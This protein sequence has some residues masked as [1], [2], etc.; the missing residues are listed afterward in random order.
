MEKHEPIPLWFVLLV[1]FYLI[2]PLSHSQLLPINTN[3]HSQ[4]GD[5]GQTHNY[6]VRVKKPKS[7]TA[8][9]LRRWHESFLP[10]TTLD[11]GDPRLIYSYRDV[12]S[13]FAARLTPEELIAM[14]AK[15]G[16]LDVQPE[17]VHQLQTTYTP[18]FLGLSQRNG[19]TWWN[20]GLGQGIIIGVIDTGITP[21]HPSFKDDGMPPSP[22]RWKGR[23][24]RT[25][26][27]TCNNK[28]IG[29]AA[30]N[31]TTVST[32]IDT[33]GHGTHVAGTAAGNFVNG[34]NVL[35]TAT[36]TAAGMAPRAHLAIYKVCHEHGCPGADILAAIDQ[37]IADGVDVLSISIGSNTTYKFYWDPVAQGS[38][39]ALSYGIMT[40]TSAGNQ[41]PNFETLSHD[42][43]WVMAV[44][45]SATDRRISAIVKLG[46]GTELPGES[47]FQPSA[48]DSSTMLPL[49]FPG[50]FG[51]YNATFCVDGSLDYIDVRGKIV[52]CSTGLTRNIEKGKVVYSAGG[53]AMIL[54]NL[55]QQGYTTSPDAHV[56]PV[57]NLG[58]RDGYEVQTYYYSLM[59]STTSTATAT[60]IFGGT[61]FGNRPSPAVGAFSSRGPATKNGGIIKPDVLAPGVNILAAWPYD[62]GP[63]PSALA[64]STFNFL[65]G[66]SM[67]APHVSGVVALIMNRHPSWPPA[68]IQS[69]IITSADDLNLDGGPIADQHTNKN[70]S[71]FATGSGQVNPTAA[72]D[73][74]L[75][76][77][78]KPN[79]YIGYVCGLGYTDDELELLYGRP[80]NCLTTNTIHAWMLNYPS[81]Q[82]S[83]PRSGGVVRI[84]RTATNVGDP[85]SFYRAR[86]TEPEGVRVDLSTY[87]LQFSWLL[88]EKSFDV[89]LRISPIGPG[90]R[91]YSD[92]KIEWVSYN[93]VVKNTIAV[94]FI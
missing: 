17:Q 53:A 16:V 33:D 48:F 90:L 37:A 34:A 62:V 30:F 79:D 26:G 81:I 91:K 39:S 67:A 7:L 54:V 77:D 61:T 40:V 13:G 2:L 44:G 72:L 94:T 23:C 59:N 18:E 5:I 70:A 42:A 52:I 10:N 86:I 4:G 69:A 50:E 3:D 9:D 35:G 56:L 38:L 19:G 68:I 66:T 93:R 14:Q 89:I 83:L 85:R 32:A 87:N 31:G 45:A 65:S 46:D 25:S 82:V 36:G 63:N 41:G 49:A 55:P 15:A 57:A 78:I 24:R 88:E 60:I 84:K 6:I 71:I 92:G 8:S 64:T 28:I 73:P 75:V 11:S 27:V 20:T 21:T 1:F 22:V 80:I 12:I 51:D 58:F 29:A 47:A 43:P 76:Y 74:G